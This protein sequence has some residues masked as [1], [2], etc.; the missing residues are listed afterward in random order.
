MV[1][2]RDYPPFDFITDADFRT[3][4]ESDYS[5]LSTCMRNEAWKSVHVLAGSIVE[6]ILVDYLLGTG[7]SKGGKDVL[8]MDL[9]SI[10]TACKDEKIITERTAD[11]STVVRSYRN[12]I[13]P[14]RIARLKETVNRNSASI[15]KS[16][17]EIITEEVAKSKEADYGFTAEQIVNKV[18]KDKSAFALLPHFLKEMKDRERERLVKEV[19]PARYFQEDFEGSLSLK[20]D[21]YEKFHRGAFE[22][23]SDECKSTV[24]RQYIRILR[25]QSGEYIVK[26]ENLF[27]RAGDLK[28]LPPAEAELAKTHLL[29]RLR[30]EQSWAILDIVEDIGPF[31]TIPEAKTVVDAYARMVGYSKAPEVQGKAD[32]LLMT[33]HDEVEPGGDVAH[34]LEERLDFWIDVYEKRPLKDAKEDLESIKA[35]WAEDI[36]F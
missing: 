32:Y 21:E 31:L 29:A 24:A 18:S 8:K 2:D 14:G 4:L 35:V 10:I 22:T 17:V 16:L 11:L 30:D 19:I 6:A 3:S 15:A 23:L 34:A 1:T 9:G 20:L 26:Y 13:H 7:Y 5:E 28:Y 36:P 25:E 33:L 27:F 12:L